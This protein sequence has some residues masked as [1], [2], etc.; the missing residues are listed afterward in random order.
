MI[1]KTPTTVSARRW[2]R[3]GVLKATLLNQIIIAGFKLGVSP[4]KLATLYTRSK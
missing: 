2:K 1:A 4:E 3:I